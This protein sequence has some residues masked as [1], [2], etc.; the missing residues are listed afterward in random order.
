MKKESNN[1]IIILTS[2]IF[3]VLL[4]FSTI[5]TNRDLITSFLIFTLGVVCIFGT[6]SNTGKAKFTEKILKNLIK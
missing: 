5:D 4:I 1:F 6:L 3:F 2:I